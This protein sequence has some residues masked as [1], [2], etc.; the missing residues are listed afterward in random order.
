MEV[1]QTNPSSH[2][3]D[4]AGDNDGGNWRRRLR[5]RKSSA[6]SHIVKNTVEAQTVD[7]ELTKESEQNKQ[8][9]H[10]VVE[11]A[12]S[13]LLFTC[14]DCKDG[15]R[16]SPDGL[17]KHFKNFH[18]GKGHP[19]SFPCSTCSF[20]ASDFTTLEQ[21]YL[22][23]K[24]SRLT[25]ETCNDK[26]LQS[27]YQP[28]EHCKTHNNQNQCEKCMFSTKDY[29]PQFLHSTCAHSTASAVKPTNGELSGNLLADAAGEPQKDELLKHTTTSCHRE[30]SRKNRWKNRD[31]TPKQPKQTA[32]DTKFLNPKSE[33]QWTSVNF[34]PFS[35]AGLLDKNG[36]LLHPTQTLE[37]TK[38][39]LE[40]TANR[41][42]QWPV[43][44]HLKGEPDLSSLSGPGPFPSEPKVK[45][46]VTPIPML[47]SG[48]KLSGLM[49]KN[50]VSVPPD[51]TTKVVGFKMVDGKKH[52]V[53]KVIPSAKPKVS[54]DTREE[55]PRLNQ[56]ERT[57]IKLDP[58]IERPTDQTCSE[59]G[60]IASAASTINGHDST[61]TSDQSKKHGLGEEEAEDQDTIGDMP[62]VDNTDNDQCSG[63]QSAFSESPDATA[64]H[65]L[66]GT[67][68]DFNVVSQTQNEKPASPKVMANS[69]DTN[70]LS[71][72][73]ADLPT[74]MQEIIRQKLTDCQEKNARDYNEI[75]SEPFTSQDD[76]S[77]VEDPS[78]SAS[79]DVGSMEKGINWESEKDTRPDIYMKNMDKKS[80]QEAPITQSCLDSL[81]EQDTE[82]V[83]NSPTNKDGVAIV[84]SN[85]ID[86]TIPSHHQNATN[87]LIVSPSEPGSLFFQDSRDENTNDVDSG[88]APVPLDQNCTM[89]T[90][91]E[92]CL[93]LL[94]LRDSCHN[95][96]LDQTHD[97]LPVTTVSQLP[98]DSEVTHRGKQK[99]L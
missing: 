87:T 37:E 8:K 33:I 1:E 95:P 67:G 41:A 47:N 92:T 62:Q 53:L 27:P 59:S 36:Q 7:K 98:D 65:A 73:N 6:V 54:T 18:G 31:F 90:V 19:L 97:E 70:D 25:Y 71:G 50:N 3:E 13:K 79:A 16:F 42:K 88:Y 43:F 74:S 17:L 9:D 48:N 5:I 68:E 46:C 22:Q 32:A 11:I 93:A 52:L 91:E 20:V 76:T 83:F 69:N 77:C 26:G 34:L 29:R 75:N 4:Q 24:N 56:E 35:D 99:Y 51:C 2:N 44:P 39:F 15:T 45:R 63:D 28:T 82:K 10:K 85:I 81:N 30:W 80:G 38:Q 21:H 55:P 12:S 78:S 84:E 60:N 64:Q 58:H 23:H 57:D 14:S 72:E 61:S 86:P 89:G 94:S 66:S 40:R 49:E 96:D